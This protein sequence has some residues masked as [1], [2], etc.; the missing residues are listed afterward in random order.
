M[1]ILDKICSVRAVKTQEATT[2]GIA[3][4]NRGLDASVDKLGELRHRRLDRVARESRDVV[5]VIGV[6]TLPL[7][8]RSDCLCNLGIVEVSRRVREDGRVGLEV[9]RVESSDQRAP[10]VVLAAKKRVTAPVG[11]SLVVAAVNLYIAT[12]SVCYFNL[13]YYVSR[14]AC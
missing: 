11:E 5:L 14:T 9:A 4:E 7:L 2:Y 13:E 3:S 12:V 10:V 1:E 6:V 8:L